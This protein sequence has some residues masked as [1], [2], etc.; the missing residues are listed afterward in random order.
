LGAY[1]LELFLRQC[2]L[3]ARVLVWVPFERL[4]AVRLRRGSADVSGT[5]RK[6]GSY[7][8]DVGIGSVFGDAED[9]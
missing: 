5:A 2:A 6:T 9:L 4:F 7:L 8:L 3:V 1:L